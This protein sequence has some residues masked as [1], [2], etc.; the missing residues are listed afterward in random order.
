V[1]NIFNTDTYGKRTRMDCVVDVQAQARPR[2][3]SDEFGTIEEA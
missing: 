2:L 3:V 1:L